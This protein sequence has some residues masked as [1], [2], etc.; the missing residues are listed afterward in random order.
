[1][2]LTV[3]KFVPTAVVAA[4]VA[5]CSWSHLF[6]PEAPVSDRSGK[7]PTITAAQL[8]PTVAPRA[9]RDPFR[10]VRAT[11]P[12]A[13]GTTKAGVSPPVVKGGVAAGQKPGATAGGTTAAGP[14]GASDM[15]EPADLLG[16]LTLNA[17]SLQGDRRVAMINGRLYEQGERL[18][19][20]ELGTAACVVACI[21]PHKV[22]LDWTGKTLELT[23]VDKLSRP[24]PALQAKG[25]SD[26]AKSNATIGAGRPKKSQ[27]PSAPSGSPKKP[28]AAP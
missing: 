5:Y 23:Y 12:L 10:P 25:T 7:L 9:E 21:L 2:T 28:P 1:M 8:S 27:V 3:G 14:Q 4:A 24:G 6:A 11:S 22:Q 20:P 15:R 19:L 16:R 18:R 26:A 17:T 13:P